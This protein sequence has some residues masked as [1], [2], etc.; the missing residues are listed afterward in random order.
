MQS[1]HGYPDPRTNLNESYFSGLGHDM[2][3][4]DDNIKTPLFLKYPGCEA[5]VIEHNIVGHIDILPTIYDILN[6]PMTKSKDNNRFRGRSLINKSIDDEIVGRILRTD[7]RLTMDLGRITSLRSNRYKYLYFHDEN[8]EMLFDIENDPKELDNKVNE[9]DSKIVSCFRD[10][11]DEYD[12][13]ITSFHHDVLLN[14]A[15]KQFHKYNIIKTPQPESICIVTKAPKRL[16]ELLL[17]SIDSNLSVGYEL[18][19]IF[20]GGILELI[21]SELFI[22][23]IQYLNEAEIENL[24]LRSFDLT[25]YLTENSKRVYLKPEVYKGVKSI[26]SNS[27]LLF[28]YNFEGFNYFKSRWFPSGARLFFSWDRKGYL[29]K[30]EPITLIQDIFSFIMISFRTLLGSGTKTDY[31]AAKEIFEYR[32]YNLKKNDGQL[33]DENIREEKNM[34]KWRDD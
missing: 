20:Y 4:T 2:I 10:K 31:V 29:Y 26:K 7:T 19:I 33:T 27:M 11:M 22:H 14:N 12:N 18:T 21:S 23:N 34:A 17:K 30:Q 9:I 24:N 5:G 3:L 6:I 28:N 1:D 32:N 25:I 16:I 13:G 15:T 8:V